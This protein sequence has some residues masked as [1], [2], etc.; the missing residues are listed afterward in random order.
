MN[1]PRLAASLFDAAPILLSGLYA[2]LA[3]GILRGGAVPPPP[4]LIA[5]AALGSVLVALSVIDLRSMRLPDALT[6]PLIAAGLLLAFA[7]GWGSPLW[8]AGSA[9]AGFLAFFALAHG[10]RALRGR[11][12]LGLGDAKLFAATG[13]WLGLEALPSVLLWATGAALL[14]VLLRLILQEPLDGS[15][16]IA[17]GPFLSLGFWL[18][19]LYGPIG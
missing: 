10:Y 15:S 6:L 11:A 5:S 3:V 19:W 16:R 12:G 9:A 7:L 14:A 4:V 1:K 13:A 18:V 17:F 2:L 8:H